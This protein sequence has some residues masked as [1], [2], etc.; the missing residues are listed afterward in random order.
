M[1]KSKKRKSADSLDELSEYQGMPECWAP[2]TASL[3]EAEDGYQ[4]LL[5]AIRSLPQ[6]YAAVLQLKF[7]YGLNNKEIAS[8]LDLSEENVKKLIQRAR[9]KLEGILEKEGAAV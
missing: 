1:L 7:V 9:K 4:K 6:N 8:A 5:E 3:V 2:S